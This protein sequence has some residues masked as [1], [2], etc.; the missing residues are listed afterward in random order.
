MKKFILLIGLPCSGKSWL[1]KELAISENAVFIDDPFDF[2]K[3]VLSKLDDNYNT[4]IIADSHFCNSKSL[5]LT[6]EI[7]GKLYDEV[8]FELVYF[9]NDKEKCLKNMK[10]RQEKGDE[11][12]VKVDILSFSKVYSI[13]ENVVQKEIWQE[14]N[15]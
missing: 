11:R 10:Q 15:R 3:D 4:Y 8:E 1:G 9:E 7:L 13:P 14:R 5:K 12:K 6:K 2:K